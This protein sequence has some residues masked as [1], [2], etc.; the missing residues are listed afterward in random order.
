[1]ATRV[2]ESV[3]L[4][5]FFSRR[6][7][8]AFFIISIHPASPASPPL[9]PVGAR[10]PPQIFAVPTFWPLYF[11]GWTYSMCIIKSGGVKLFKIQTN[12]SLPLLT[13][14]WCNYINICIFIFTYINV[15]CASILTGLNFEEN[16]PSSAFAVRNKIRI[17]RST[18]GITC[19]QIWVTS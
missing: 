14:P 8:N 9:P 13:G 1:M 17:P 4:L 10:T 7:R 16:I 12:T 19:H 11:G 3:F 5:R 2:A 18:A 6:F 15:S